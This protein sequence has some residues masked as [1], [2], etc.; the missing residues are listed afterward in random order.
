L[1]GPGLHFFDDNSLVVQETPIT[2]NSNGD[3]KIIPVG[4][5][6]AF[7]FVFVKT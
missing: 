3:N 4:N 6:N 2:L 1:L 7:S 5:T